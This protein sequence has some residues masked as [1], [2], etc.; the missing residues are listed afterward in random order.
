MR[1]RRDFGIAERRRASRRPCDCGGIFNETPVSESRRNVERRAVGVERLIDPGRAGMDGRRDC[2]PA[3][4]PPSP[5]P[6]ASCRRPPSRDG[7]SEGG[8]PMSPARRAAA[9]PGSEMCPTRSAP[10]WTVESPLSSG[11]TPSAVANVR[12]SAPPWAISWATMSWMVKW[13][14]FSAKI[15]ASGIFDFAG[16][17]PLQHRAEIF[18][19][20][21]AGEQAG[22][23]GLAQVAVLDADVLEDDLA[24]G[25]ARQHGLAD[26]HVLGPRRRGG[27][28]TP[29]SGRKRREKET[30]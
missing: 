13:S 5:C 8:E 23:L 17:H 2:R 12:L 4:R 16:L 6:P 10:E 3:R 19:R 29:R 25:G 18:A 1:I 24:L 11:N 22:R 20:Q 14:P 27:Q 26:G 21:R 15:S 28:E 30:A 7:E 9:R